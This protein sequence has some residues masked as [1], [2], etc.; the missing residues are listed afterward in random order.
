MRDIDVYESPGRFILIY[1]DTNV[2]KTTSSLLSLPS[3]ILWILTEPRPVDLILRGV[4]KVTGQE[5]KYIK[6]DAGD[7][8]ERL[9]RPI[10][11]EN[12][13]TTLEFLDAEV[14]K[15]KLEYKSVLFD[16]F[17]YWMNA[18]MFDELAEETNK[19]QVFS[20]SNRELLNSARIDEAAYG[21]LARLTLRLCKQ[22]GRLSQKGIIV[23][24]TALVQENPKWDATLE[25]A[26]AFAGKMFGQI[27]P[28]TVDCIGFIESRYDDAGNVIYPPIIRFEKEK[29]RGYLT[30]WTGGRHSKLSGPLDWRK[31]LK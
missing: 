12:F 15:E 11:P 10:A 22:F 31:I 14:S 20:K 7:Y 8:G 4:G 24:G 2:G 21:A 16:G 3:P 17:T 27:F 1:S 9:I 18:D 6:V 30:K 23:I 25:A 26:P 13:E 28:P 5:N 19:A 29:G